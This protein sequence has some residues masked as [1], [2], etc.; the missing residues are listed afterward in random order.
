[1]P[2]PDAGASFDHAVCTIAEE[3]AAGVLI[4]LAVCFCGWRSDAYLDEFG[5][6]LA[7]SN[8]PDPED[9]LTYGGPS[10]GLRADATQLLLAGIAE[11]RASLAR[12]RRLSSA[13]WRLDSGAGSLLITVTF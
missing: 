2:E 1:M 13:L 11:E 10:S 6:D 4:W 9:P 7:R 8:H 3:D 5:A 12:A